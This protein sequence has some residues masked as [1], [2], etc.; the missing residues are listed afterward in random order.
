MLNKQ[1]EGRDYIAGD[2]SIADI[3]SIG[4]AQ[5]WKG[6]S[7]DI[8][9]FPNVKAWMERMAARPAVAKGLLVGK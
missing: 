2:Y 4:W 1:L 7:Q 8:E 6:Q 3:A 5:G 9:E